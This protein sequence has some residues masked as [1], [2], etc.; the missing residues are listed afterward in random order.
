MPGSKGQT[1]PFPQPPSS[2]D[3]ANDVSSGL[4]TSRSRISLI[5]IAIDVLPPGRE[6]ALLRDDVVGNATD[7]G[8]ADGALLIRI[9]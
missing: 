4:G 9:R 2:A 3:G 5:E 7:G 8:A 6:S 1:P